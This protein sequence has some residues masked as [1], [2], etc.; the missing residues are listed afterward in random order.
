MSE[1]RCV[2]IGAAGTATGYGI[3]RCLR[4]H[5]GESVRVVT[6]DVN[7]AH[8]VAATEL[9]DAHAIVPPVAERERF[10]EAF[11]AGVAEHGV[12]TYVPLLT[13]ELELGAELAE[14]HGVQ[15]LGP[16]ERAARL[17]AD[18]LEAARWMA[19]AGIAAPPTVPAGE[20][21]WWP[22]GVVVKPRSGQGSQEVEP[23]A[24]E[25][26]L[27]RAHARGERAIAQRRCQPPEVSVDAFAGRTNFRAVCRERIEV[28][29]G[30]CT[31]AR[32]FADPELAG[33]VARL[34]ELLPH[35]GVLC[36]QFM[37]GPDGWEVTDL[38]PRAGAATP[39]SALAGIDVTAAAF[40]EL[41]GEQPDRFLGRI[42]GEPYVVRHYEELLRY[43]T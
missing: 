35:T 40:A 42:E 20:A 25:A 11:G 15:L 43:P 9:A 32:L 33:V 38:N 13:R 3:V 24:S 31:K 22:E 10:V 26:D 19:D 36:V 29:A 27:P 21:P 41:W 18:K 6:A 8:L 28:K 12:D 17:C 5:W 4:R 37:R 2:W 34:A 30:V 14:A 23:I 1:A 16:T 39:M 7:P